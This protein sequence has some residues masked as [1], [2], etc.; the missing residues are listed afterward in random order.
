MDI[1]GK[2][3]GASRQAREHVWL[4]SSQI[5][6]ICLGTQCTCPYLESIVKLIYIPLSTNELSS[7]N[8]VRIE[9]AHGG[10]NNKTQD[11]KLQSTPVNV[12]PCL[13]L[14]PIR[15][16][17][18]NFNICRSSSV[19]FTRHRFAHKAT[20]MSSSLCLL[21]HYSTVYKSVSTM[22]IVCEDA[23][24]VETTRSYA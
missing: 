12:N 22:G 15:S 10:C 8:P 21:Q 18:R 20:Y 2:G 16:H 6:L 19:I 14:L 11:N 7:L 23:R 24:D 4:S 1:G 3:G 9:P 13:V 17:D 5:A